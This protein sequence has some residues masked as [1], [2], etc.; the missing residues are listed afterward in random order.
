MLARQLVTDTAVAVVSHPARSAYNLLTEPAVYLRAAAVGLLDKRI[1]SRLVRKPPPIEDRGTLNPTV[2]EAKLAQVAG[3][4]LS[5]AKIELFVHGGDALAS[6]HRV[7]REA[8]SRIDVL[9]YLWDSDAI[10]EEIAVSLA[11]RAGPDL[12]VRVLVDGGGNMISG[13]P[14]NASAAEANR[15][16]CWLA[17]Q[18]YVEV[19]R[20][21]NP[22]AR[23]DHRKLVLADGQV[24]WSGGRNFT[25]ASFFDYHD[26][27]YTLEGPLAAEMAEV[28]D[29]FWHAQG[30]ASALPLP[31]A[32]DVTFANASARLVRTRPVKRQLA[33]VLYTAVDQAQHHVYLENPYLTDARLLAKLARARQ[34]GADVRVVL[35]I[36][37]DSKIIDSSNK[38][39]ANRLLRAG[40][41]VYLYPGVTHVKATAV[42]SAWAYIGT[43]NFDALSMRHN[44]ELGV[45][46]A[47]G[48]VVTALESDLFEPDFRPEWELTE[49]LP[50]TG[51]EYF[52]EG[53]AS[54]FL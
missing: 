49:P 39:T 30:G 13:L 32:S 23:F 46:I 37:S 9:M 50:L 48:P 41:R 4:D 1:A 51:P 47:P 16:V 10:G 12:P 19:M 54:L 6:L 45:A 38:V 14:P 26:L 28:F 43:G 36:H 2:L 8:N 25:A 42:D 31:G 27:S 11:S 44:R 34:R 3:N 18:P 52:F 40:I 5:P 15:I 35:T 22:A 53:L 7:I 17:R 20:T 33:D 24:A 29:N 21:R